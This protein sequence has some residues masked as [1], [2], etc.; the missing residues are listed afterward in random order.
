[1]SQMRV[2]IR[3][4]NDAGEF[5]VTKFQPKDKAGRPT[6]TQAQTLRSATTDA[7]SWLRRNDKHG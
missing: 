2:E 4:V 1:M 7:L 6:A 3:I 5:S